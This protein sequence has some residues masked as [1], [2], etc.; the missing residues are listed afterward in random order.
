[1]KLSPAYA[2]QT[3]TKKNNHNTGKG[4]FFSMQKQIRLARPED[5]GA[6]L[7]IYAP[8]VTGS[9]VTFEYTVP[10]RESFCSRIQATLE[11]FPWLVCEIGGK[12]AGYAYASPFQKRA[13]YQW[14]AELSVYVSPSF[15]RQGVAGAL[16][17]TLLPLLEMQGYYNLYA[18]ITLPNPASIGF[19]QSYGFE[20]AGIYHGT[21][22]KFGKW[23]DMAVLEKRLRD[24][25]YTGIPEKPV[26]FP[27]LKKA[28]IS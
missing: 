3:P 6:L 17:N 18:L 21:G 20:T 9:A 2:E 25:S 27:T 5:C 8:Y 1:M 16:Y 12:I 10:D 11:Q 15:H 13:A 23:H 22:F 14:D 19:H 4:T 28:G 7:A 24:P 26:P